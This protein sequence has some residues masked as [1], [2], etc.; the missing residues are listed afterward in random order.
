MTLS[1]WIVKKWSCN[2]LPCDHNKEVQ[3]LDWR[4]HFWIT[5]AIKPKARQCQTVV[6]M[7]IRA[8]D[9]STRR[10]PAFRRRAGVR[11]SAWATGRFGRRPPTS[12]WSRTVGTSSGRPTSTVRRKKIQRNVSKTPTNHPSSDERFKCCNCCWKMKLS[13]RDGRKQYP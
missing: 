5:F 1:V 8:G 12:P 4:W 2:K 9:G 7:A 3:I 11:R 13:R 6:K 10:W